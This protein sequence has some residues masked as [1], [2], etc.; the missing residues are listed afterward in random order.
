M[1]LQA[2]NKK[3]SCFLNTFWKGHTTLIELKIRDQNS[4]AWNGWEPITKNVIKITGDQR[5][6]LEKPNTI[7]AVKVHS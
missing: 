7:L 5:E 3:W 2:K 4:K 1:K 6:V